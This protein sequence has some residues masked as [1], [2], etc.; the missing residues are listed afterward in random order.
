MNKK[1]YSIPIAILSVLI[2]AFFTACRTDEPVLLPSKTPVTDET[3][4][5]EVVGFYLLNEGNMGS[6]KATLDYFDFTTGIYTKNMYAATNPQV[7]SELGDVGNDLQIYGNK[8]YAVLNTSGFVE[9]MD[10]TT[11]KHIG[12]IEIPNCR[13]ITFYNGKAYVSSYA[14]PV[15]LSNN[16]Q[17][18]YVAEIDTASLQITRTVHVGYQP[19]EMAIVNGT[20]YVAN[21]GGYMY[22]EYDNTVS[23]IC[24]QTFTET[25]K[26]EVGINLHRLKSDNKGN[27][28]IS[29]RGNYTDIASC[30]YILN[31]N[32]L[33]VDKKLNIP[34][35][36]LCIVGDSAYVISSEFNFLSGNTNIEY[37]LINTSTQNIEANNFITDRT[38]TA[39]KMP[40]GIAVHPITRDIYITDA[41]SYIIPGTVYCYSKTGKRKWYVTTGDIPAHIAFLT[42][43]NN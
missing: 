41:K 24:L 40:Y 31:T 26:V 43:Q 6:N 30:L 34:V 16:T 8:L 3:T 22:P 17:V 27:L 15:E 14:G 10:A 28:Y 12:M 32:T 18:G 36:N 37:A 23:V 9:V 2:V 25:Q 11:A 21:S 38:E 4:N 13:Y 19:E 5:S 29:S 7:V 20:L 35:S 33:Q 39:I 1:N 42:K